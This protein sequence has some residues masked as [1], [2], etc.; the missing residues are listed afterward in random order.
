MQK[1]A[2]IVCLVALTLTSKV[3]DALAPRLFKTSPLL[4]LVL[5]AN[6]LHLALTCRALSFLPWIV[7][8][9]L[10]R[11]AEDPICF[12]LGWRFRDSAIDLLRRTFPTLNVS[13]ADA[14]FRRA[15]YMAILVEPGLAVCTLAGVTRMKPSV[16]ALL[17][18]LGTGLR[19]VAIHSAGAFAPSQLGWVVEILHIPLVQ[20]TLLSLAIV[21]SCVSALPLV[22]GLSASS[23]SAPMSAVA[24]TQG[25]PAIAVRFSQRRADGHCRASAESEMANATT[26]TTAAAVDNSTCAADSVDDATTAVVPLEAHDAARAPAEAAKAAVK[27]QLDALWRVWRDELRPRFESEGWA[28]PKDPLFDTPAKEEALL[29]RFLNAERRDAPRKPETWLPKA[30]RRL[31]ETAAFRHD[32]RCKDFHRVGMA[33]RL[34]MHASNPG[35]TVYFG[36]IGLRSA[37]GGPVLIGR[38][39]LM[40]EPS[41]P[42]D[43]MRAAQHLRAGVMVAERALAELPAG[44]KGSYI[45]DVGSFPKREMGPDTSWRYWDA[46]SEGGRAS[47]DAV[48]SPGVGPHLSGHDTL[49]GLSVLREAMRLM[50][51]FY[52]ETLHRIFFYRPSRAF[53]LV[54][55][56]FRL[57]AS[58]ATRSRFVL[59]REGQE[60][61]FFAP[62]SDGGCALE[63]A[64]APREFGGDGPSLGGDRFLALAVQRYDATATLAAAE[65]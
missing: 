55:A 9:I 34:M 2:L 44:V 37:D 65:D 36:D 32:Y 14:S 51:T 30:R 20:S 8:G 3:G 10:R 48:S 45:L 24:Q 47:E 6:D 23:S 17:N 1:P 56:V 19:L 41:K 25:A 62:S 27:P 18:I 38:V 60:A 7:V 42:S 54:F 61:I 4:L 11:L 29:V 22:H 64:A 49:T 43:N 50:A 35:A 31:E 40:I 58:P 5:N 57:W 13:R 46:D 28:I 21:Q 59:V 53:R 16:F 63:R 12:A 33:R 52:P 39:S 26:P 15:S